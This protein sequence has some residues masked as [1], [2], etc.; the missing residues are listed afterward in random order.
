MM[1]G[2]A[3]CLRAVRRYPAG[4]FPSGGESRLR[5]RA[6]KLYVAWCACIPETAT[7]TSHKLIYRRAAQSLGRDGAAQ[8]LRSNGF[9][10]AGK[11]PRSDAP[12]DS[13]SRPFRSEAKPPGNDK[14]LV[15]PGFFK[16]SFHDS[17]NV[18]GLIPTFFDEQPDDLVNV[19]RLIAKKIDPELAAPLFAN[20]RGL[21]LRGG[22][23]V[24][25]SSSSFA[26]HRVLPAGARPL[27]PA[28]G[29]YFRE[30]STTQPGAPREMGDGKPLSC[31]N[32][33]QDITCISWG[34]GA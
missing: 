13:K 26:H 2:K 8:G 15:R 17:R 25:P 32:L 33:F 6:S 30:H 16:G 19:Y 21:A 34:P 14:S 10:C 18:C 3:R 11:P 7:T 20:Y 5:D 29:C 23:P 9:R 28:H 24:I 12:A 22:L 1:R 27:R 31:T 4:A